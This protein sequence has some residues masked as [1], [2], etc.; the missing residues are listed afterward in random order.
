MNKT[1]FDF[2]VK[3]ISSESLVAV[4]VVLENEFVENL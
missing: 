4:E 2:A 1:Y 3:I